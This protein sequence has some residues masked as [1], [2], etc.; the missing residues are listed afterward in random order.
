MVTLTVSALSGAWSLGDYIGL[1]RIEN[2]A[3]DA[4]KSLCAMINENKEKFVE[5]IDGKLKEIFKEVKMKFK[6]DEDLKLVKNIQLRTMIQQ[7]YKEIEELRL[8]L[9]MENGNGLQRDWKYWERVLLEDYRIEEM[10]EFLNEGKESHK[11]IKL[12]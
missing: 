12:F 10:M 11:K 2:C 4:M 8:G 5:E 7:H 6:V 9:L 1:W 3:E